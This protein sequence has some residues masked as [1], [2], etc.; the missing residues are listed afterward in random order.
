MGS[1]RLH[2]RDSWGSSAIRIAP[3][4]LFPSNGII[5]LHCEKTPGFLICAGTGMVGMYAQKR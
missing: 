5:A 2:F 4:F 1:I 3:E